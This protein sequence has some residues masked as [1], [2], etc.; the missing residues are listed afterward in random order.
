METLAVAIANL[1]VFMLGAA[2]GSFLNVVVYRLPAQLS[3]L[4]PPSRCPHCLHRLGI[5][6][7]VP[8]LGWLKLRGRCHWCR[9]PISSRYP[10]VEA[11]SGVLFLLVFWQ[12]GWSVTT[13]GYWT[14]LSWLLALS[15][16]DFDTMT[17]P[18]RL[19]SSGLVVGL[20]FQAALGWQAG[21]SGAA[22]HLMGGICS[23]V[24]GIW[25]F[26]AIALAGTVAFG[27]AAMGG[28]DPKLAAMIGAWLGWKLLLLTGFLACA[29]GA[30][31]GGGA[32]YLGIINRKQPMP[33][34]PF[35]AAG[36]ALSV[37]WGSVIISTYL[38]LF[39]VY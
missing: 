2:I 21:G 1:L 32:I 25:L 26:E 33:F 39:P 28:G 18:N 10:L 19:T 31:V 27:Q 38:N 15:L 7:N 14:F 8:I 13:L 9:A 3:L 17:L 16:I 20:G 4:Y 34:G 36:A 35:L 11:A 23:A 6:E 24:V 5:R 29:L 22:T 37:F 30:F 12:F